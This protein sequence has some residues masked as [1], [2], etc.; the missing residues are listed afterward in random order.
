MEQ[1]KH[2]IKDYIKD[3]IKVDYISMV[4]EPNLPENKSFSVSPLSVTSR[5]IA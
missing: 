4:V 5:S 1:L 3:Y 2:L